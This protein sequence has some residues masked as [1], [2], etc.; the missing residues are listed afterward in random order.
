MSERDVKET[1]IRVLGAVD[2]YL[3]L[4]VLQFV[5]NPIVQEM[6]KRE[7]VWPAVPDV[8]DVLFKRVDRPYTILFDAYTGGNNGRKTVHSHVDRD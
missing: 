6:A 1:P 2:I 8:Y 7:L 4:I 3:G 5:T